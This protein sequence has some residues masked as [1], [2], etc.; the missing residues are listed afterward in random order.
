MEGT[1][2][3]GFLNAL[4][5][6]VQNQL[7]AHVLIDG[8]VIAINDNFTVDIMVN[9]ITY[10]NVP[11]KVVIGS[12]AS[13]YEVPVLNSICLVKWRDGNIG[14]P[15]IDSFNQ[16][17]HYYI[18]VNDFDVAVKNTFKISANLTEF[19]GGESG[20]MV[21]VNDLVDRMNLI[22]NAYNDLVTKFNAHSHILTLTSGT[23]TAAPTLSPETTVLTDTIADDIQSTVITQ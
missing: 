16:V 7:R 12:Q 15:Q 21:L 11:I 2:N 3:F 22:E 13:I 10:S 17:D 6:F 14:L 20:G 19:N 18:S 5:K 8:T 4:L 23:G 1:S 9:S